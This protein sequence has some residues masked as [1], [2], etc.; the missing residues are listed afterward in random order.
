MCGIVWLRLKADNRDHDLESK[1]RRVRLMRSIIYFSGLR[2]FRACHEL[3]GSQ[4]RWEPGTIG[5]LIYFPC[6]R[7]F[8]AY[9]QLVG[10]QNR[11]TQCTRTEVLLR[12]RGVGLRIWRMRADK[13][14]WSPIIR[15]LDV[16]GFVW[17]INLILRKIL[18]FFHF[19]FVH[20]C[21]R[22]SVRFLRSSFRRSPIDSV[23]SPRSQDRGHI[24]R[25]FR[26][27]ILRVRN[28]IYTPGPSIASRF[29]IVLRFRLVVT[30]CQKSFSVWGFSCTGSNPWW[31]M[32][33]FPAIVFH[34]EGSWF[35][36]IQ[37]ENLLKNRFLSI[38][39]FRVMSIFG[40]DLI[41]LRP[42]NSDSGT[43]HSQVLDYGVFTG[44]G[45]S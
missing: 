8:R 12:G 33:S 14:R 37:S 27:L 3:A 22:C 43:I 32:I 45:S 31:W 36:T 10:I 42:F 26:Y 17:T 20:S 2:E 16:T 18:S 35:E 13:A 15:N 29:F 34:K 28:C 6:V 24:R 11:I 44:S 9:Q 7:G 38:D 1:R 21:V 5:S 41:F 40:S 39:S 23:V 25:P 4:N 30:T 19:F